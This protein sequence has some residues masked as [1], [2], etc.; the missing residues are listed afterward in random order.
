MYSKISMAL[1]NEPDLYDSLTNQVQNVRDLGRSWGL[2]DDQIDEC[3]Q[4][5][6]M[7]D[8]KPKISRRLRR[9]CLC[10]FLV[11]FCFMGG[12]S[13]FFTTVTLHKATRLFV[14]KHTQS[15]AYPLMRGIRLLTLPISRT[16]DLRGWHEMECL[17]PNPLSAVGPPD[18]YPCQDVHNIII[19]NEPVRKFTERYY[20]FGIPFV[21]KDPDRKLVHFEDLKDLYLANTATLEYNAKS[22]EC[23]NS[24]VDSID[25]ILHKDRTSQDIIEAN[26]GVK[27]RIIKAGSMRLIRTLS[28]KP[29][30]IPHKGEVAAEMFVFIDAPASEAHLMP[31]TYFG[32]SWLTQASGSREVTLTPLPSCL[33]N[34]TEVSVV[35]QPKDILFYSGFFWQL[36]TFP[37][38]DDI[39][40]QFLGSFF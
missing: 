39:S 3:V 31:Q 20:N 40:I 8:E 32:N 33:Q 17:V 11:L 1:D 4:K 2:D 5:A 13:L 22:L 7:V 26:I 16:F 30:F 23:T 34:C 29:Y 15:I 38:G 6:L 19:F 12:M 14:T 21:A 27:W 25:D 36:K 37:F 35:L 9:G 28:A 10:C 18:C 24:Y